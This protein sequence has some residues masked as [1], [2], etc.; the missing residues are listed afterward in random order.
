MPRTG[1]LVVATVLTFG[2]APV[3]AAPD[4]ATGIDFADTLEQ[5]LLACAACHG[6]QGEGL[7]KP[8]YYPRLAGKPVGLPL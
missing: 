3:H 8:E 7:R 2:A 5:R 1:L 6:K 4:P